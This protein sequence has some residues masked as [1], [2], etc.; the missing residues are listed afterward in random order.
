MLNLIVAV[1]ISWGYNADRGDHFVMNNEKA[2]IIQSQKEYISL[3]GDRVFYYY[4]DIKDIDDVV[5]VDDDNP[6]PDQ[7]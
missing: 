6:A 3:G 7:K 4:V 1:L 5:I 2:S